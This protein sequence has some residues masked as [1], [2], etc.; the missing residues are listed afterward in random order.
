M[1]PIY[2]PL[3][4]I[5]MTEATVRNRGL[6]ADRVIEYKGGMLSLHKE[7]PSGRVEVVAVAPVCPDAEDDLVEELVRAHRH[8]DEVWEHLQRKASEAREKGCVS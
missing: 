4:D 8:F 1:S 7:Y 6:P 2:F 3:F 5:C